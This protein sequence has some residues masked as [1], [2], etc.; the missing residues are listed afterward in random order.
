V[1]NNFDTGATGQDTKII[2]QH[3]ARFVGGGRAL[4]LGRLGEWKI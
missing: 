2:V 4:F 1:K 3:E